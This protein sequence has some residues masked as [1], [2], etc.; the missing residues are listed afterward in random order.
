MF[1]WENSDVARHEGD[2]TVIAAGSFSFDSSDA[3]VLLDALPRFLLIPGGHPSAAMT[4][5]TL[6]MIVPEIAGPRIGAAIVTDRLVDV[7]L[8]QVLRAALDQDDNGGFGWIGALR[9]PRIGRALGLMHEEPAYPWTPELLC[10]AVAMSRSAFAKRFRTLVGRAPLDYLLHWRMRIA[11]DRL[12][13]GSTVA[14]AALHVGYASESA[15]R[16]AFKRLHGE[17]PKRYGKK[18][19]D[20]A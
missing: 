4:R 3:D 19:E 10:A 14:A 2:D 18:A 6:Q 11:R 16:N 17:A 9:D 20:L 1:D 8:V 12:R 7:L 5:S 13:R 15:F